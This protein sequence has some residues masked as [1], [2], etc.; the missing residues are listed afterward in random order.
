[1]T[2]TVTSQPMKRVEDW[3][4]RLI[5][6]SKR[7]NLLYFHKAKRGSLPISQ[8]DMQAIFNALVLKKRRLEFWLPPEETIKPER[9]EKA[10]GKVKAKIAKANAKADV[11]EIVPEETKQRP[12]ANQLVSGSLTRADLE[13]NLK[14]LQWRSLLDYRERGVRILH[15]AFGTLNWVDLETKE[16][17]SRP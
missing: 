6:L 7:N 10:K 5:D 14:R 13:R 4:S 9:S 3:K 17:V 1:M 15:A 16:K 8:P 11:K 2:Q 12:T